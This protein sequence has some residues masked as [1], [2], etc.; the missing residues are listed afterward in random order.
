MTHIKGRRGLLVDVVYV[1]STGERGIPI[2]PVTLLS[3]RET[4]GNIREGFMSVSIISG[5]INFRGLLS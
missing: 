2:Y 1:L 5:K 3:E 4:T